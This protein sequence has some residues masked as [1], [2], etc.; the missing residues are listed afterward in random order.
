VHF[1]PQLVYIKIKGALLVQDE[2]AYVVHFCNHCSF[3]FDKAKV[4]IDLIR[5]FSE[6]AEKFMVDPARAE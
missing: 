6:I 3:V 1:K 5:G 4:R 2:D